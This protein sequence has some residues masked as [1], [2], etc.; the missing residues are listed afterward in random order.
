MLSRAPS[1]AL[2]ELKRYWGFIHVAQ[3]KPPFKKFDLVVSQEPIGRTGLWGLMHSEAL[4]EF[5]ICEV[6]ANYYNFLSPRDRRMMLCLL[7]RADAVRAVNKTIAKELRQ[8]GI[9]N[10]L[11]IPSVYVRV[12]LFRPLYGYE[13][14]EK[15]IMFVGDFRRDYQKGYDVLSRVFTEVLREEP[16]VKLYIAGARASKNEI[17]R[18]YPML[19]SRNVHVYP[20]CRVEELVK[21]YSRSSVFLCTSRFEGGPRA[22]FEAMACGTPFVS[23]KT[24]LALDLAKHGI[25]GFFA[26]PD[27]LSRYVTKLVED[28]RLR[29]IM[30]LKARQ[31]VTQECEWCKSIARYARSYVELLI[32]R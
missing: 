16:D 23:T 6:H 30:G 29:S 7:R 15:A 18:K 28:V 26:E 10:V 11:V 4:R 12:D 27:E 19:A 1:I 2:E 14:R 31:L 5:W 22:L 25:E 24:G 20:W 9:D 32:N 13:E 21:L 3:G 8:L 17:A